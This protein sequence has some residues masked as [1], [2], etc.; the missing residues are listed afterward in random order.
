MEF[1]VRRT[2]DMINEKPI[3]DAYINNNEWCIQIDDLQQ[4]VEVT[5]TVGEIIIMK[6]TESDMPIIEIYDDLRK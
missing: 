2:S 1:I 6:N 3:N 5:N 4:L